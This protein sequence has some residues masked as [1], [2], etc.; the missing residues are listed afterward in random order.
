FLIAFLA[1]AVL[2]YRLLDIRWIVGKSLFITAAIS[3]VLWTVTAA[4]FLLANLVGTTVATFTGALIVVVI[5]KPTWNLLERVFD[6]LINFGGYD[7]KKATGEVFDIVRSYGELEELIPRLAEKFTKY[8]S[9]QQIAIFIK[10]ENGGHVVGSFL[11]GFPVTISKKATTLFTLA[12]DGKYNILELEEMEWMQEFGT[13]KKKAKKEKKWLQIFQQLEIETLIPLVVED[14]IVGV[15]VFGKRRFEGAMHSRDINFLN[16]VRAGIS[17]AF[18][19]AAKF[20]QI[21]ELYEQL[22]EVDQ[23]KTE[24]ISI[25]SH[26]FRTPLS[27]I[28]WNIETIMEM[29]ICKAS[30][31]CSQALDD[32]YDRTLFLNETLDRLFDSLAIESGKLKL[33]K[34][35]I[36]SKELFGEAASK[37]KNQ[38]LSKEVHCTT[39]IGDF[40]L[41]V[42]VERIRSTCRSL[43]TNAL[44]YTAAKGTVSLKVSKEGHMVKIEISDTGIGVPEEAK[45]KIFEKFYRAQNAIHTYTDG[46]GLG[47]YLAKRIVEIHHGKISFVSELGKGT[48]FTILLPLGAEKKKTKKS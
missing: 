37:F 2:R 8:F 43:L 40:P 3:V 45:D 38:C 15:M 18:E 41:A 17:P 29:P 28:R 10:S 33:K 44:Q 5:F 39:S 14:K 23:A 4:S 6:S 20:A 24:F 21:K 19:N 25:V 7:A 36:N 32:A 27:A 35:E 26:R 30:K 11:E 12:S 22:K 16:L 13:D 48:K 46:Q 1:N 9:L 34:Q 42:D 47:L 31:D